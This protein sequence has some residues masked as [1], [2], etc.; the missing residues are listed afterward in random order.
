MLVN[1]ILVCD[2]RAMTEHFTNERFFDLTPSDI[3]EQQEIIRPFRNK[4]VRELV[5]S[6]AAGRIKLG[7]KA[8]EG[9]FT[10]DSDFNEGT[11]LYPFRRTTRS[12]PRW[13]TDSVMK[14]IG[15][16][17][18]SLQEN[19]REL[20]SLY[21]VITDKDNPSYTLLMGRVD[22][23]RNGYSKGS[24][25]AGLSLSEAHAAELGMERHVPIQGVN[26]EDLALIVQQ[27]AEIR[28]VAEERQLTVID[29]VTLTDGE[30]ELVQFRF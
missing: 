21:S 29:P 25:I 6:G 9:F 22:T 30:G 13:L 12:S 28:A 24:Y 11:M 17:P 3:E 14:G 23:V 20:S 18:V 8:L 15:Q 10:I 5:R 26:A 19:P 4:H 1:R 2:N 16:E 27:L 7:T